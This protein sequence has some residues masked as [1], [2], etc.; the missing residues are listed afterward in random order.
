MGFDPWGCKPLWAMRG[1]RGKD[2]YASLLLTIIRH[3]LK[4]ENALI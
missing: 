2:L 3:I 1:Y 4:G